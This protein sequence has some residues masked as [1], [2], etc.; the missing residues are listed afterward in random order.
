ML[1]PLD[2][3]ER[4]RLGARTRRVVSVRRNVRLYSEDLVRTCAGWARGPEGANV[5]GSKEWGRIAPER[6]NGD[7]M[8]PRYSE[9]YRKRLDLPPGVHPVSSI[10]QATMAPV[11][12]L[13]TP[14]LSTS[15]TSS[16][17]SSLFD[18]PAEES[19]F[20][21][22]TDMKWGEFSVLGF[23]DG[24]A[25]PSALQ[26]DLNEGARSQRSVKRQTLSWNDFSD[27]GFSRGETSLS[28]TLQ[29]GPSLSQ[30]VQQWPTQEKD[31]HRKLKKSVQK[32]PPF[33]W[34]TAPIMDGREEIIEEG[35]LD[36]FCDLLYGGGWTDRTETTFRECNW[37]LVRI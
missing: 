37:A 25:A 22:L 13:S 23:G 10:V 3:F 34:D 15:S 28:E 36:I 8:E 33:G 5:R 19:R 24:S 20:R 21:S 1:A 12:P 2:S 26:F 6:R 17:R 7:R 14:A 4:P 31:I 16:G 32:L 27:A 29:F 11:S 35:F 18:D 9:V 30:T